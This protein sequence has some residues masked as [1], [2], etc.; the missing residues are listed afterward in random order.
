VLENQPPSKRMRL[1]SIPEEDKKSTYA[2][3]FYEVLD[4]I[5]LNIS[6]RFSEISKLQFLNLLDSTQF[7]LFVKCFPDELFSSLVDT[8]GPFFDANCVK[9]EISAIYSDTDMK[10]STVFELHQYLM[11]LQLSSVFPE[12]SKLCRLILTIPATSSSAERS[13]SY[14][15]RIKT[16]LRNSQKQ[17]KLSALALINIESALLEDMRS[18]PRF[19]ETVIDV[20]AGQNKNR[21]IDLH[22]K[23]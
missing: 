18:S 23:N 19:E 22:F 16:Y 11:S 21:R 12:S 9:S 4:V 3:L 7:T 8:Y 2:R 10:K 6:Q 15:K 13:F 14:L 5:I 17:D 20:F 1:D